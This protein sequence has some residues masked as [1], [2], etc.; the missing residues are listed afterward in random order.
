MLEMLLYLK[1]QILD[2]ISKLLPQRIKK[3]DYIRG[4]LFI[5]VFGN[6][7]AT[8]AYEGEMEGLKNLSL[9]TAAGMVGTVKSKNRSMG[10]PTDVIF[11]GFLRDVA[12]KRVNLKQFKVQEM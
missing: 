7:Y 4:D 2:I 12:T 9:L 6:R 5:G 11:L 10:N 3:S 1:F 8:D